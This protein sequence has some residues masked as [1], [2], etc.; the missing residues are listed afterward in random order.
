MVWAVA[1]HE[2]ALF[3][4]MLRLQGSEV[5]VTG[6]AEMTVLRAGEDF[7]GPLQHGAE[8]GVVQALA[9]AHEEQRLEETYGALHRLG[10]GI[11]ED[12]FVV[13]DAEDHRLGL[14]PVTVQVEHAQFVAP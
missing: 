8:V 3:N 2:D 11:A 10:V 14:L 5:T 13:A 12:L 7:A 9:T 1:E 6:Q 4:G